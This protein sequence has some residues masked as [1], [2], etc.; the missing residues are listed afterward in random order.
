MDDGNMDVLCVSRA[1]LS[2]DKRIYVPSA[3]VV[4]TLPK[5]PDHYPDLKLMRRK[6][7]RKKAPDVAWKSRIEIGYF[8][9]IIY[10]VSPPLCWVMKYG[11]PRTRRHCNVLFCPLEYC[12]IKCSR[13]NFRLLLWVTY[14][15]FLRTE[16]PETLKNEGSHSSLA[17]SWGNLG[18]IIS[19]RIYL[20]HYNPLLGSFQTSLVEFVVII[21]GGYIIYTTLNN[22][23]S[24]LLNSI[25]V[26]H[27]LNVI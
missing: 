2:R 26:E 5:Y 16:K 18:L 17:T 23:L 6:R 13:F 20:W 1:P 15:I 24:F 11:G 4:V 25:I 21:R 3:N 10:S 8:S 14:S 7:G 12:F 9:V 22:S 27:S 19:R